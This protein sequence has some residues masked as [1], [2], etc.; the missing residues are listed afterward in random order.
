[1]RT[2]FESNAEGVKNLAYGLVTGH[3][4]HVATRPTAPETGRLRSTYVGPAIPCGTWVVP[5]AGRSFSACANHS[6]G[7]FPC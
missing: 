2:H 6:D 4:E 5:S 3:D 7:D 1:M